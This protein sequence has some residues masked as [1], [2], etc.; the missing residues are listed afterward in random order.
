M[1][2]ALYSNSLKR[3]V[4]ALLLF[5]PTF[6]GIQSAN[7]AANIWSSTGPTGAYVRS[8][9]IAPTATP[10][11][12][13][14]TNG[15]GVYKTLAGSG[16]W[17][18]VNTGLTNRTVTALTVDP[19]S[20]STLYAGSAGNG[21]F[22][23]AN[24]GTAW[25]ATGLISDTVNAIDI[26][27]GT[28]YAGTSAGGVYRSNNGGGLWAQVNNGL[29]NLHVTSIA[30]SPGFA[31]DTTAFAGTIGGGVFKTT[32]DGAN[33]TAVNTN[34]TD[35]QVTAL[36]AS[37]DFVADNT[38][39][40]GTTTGGV[41][42]SS[43]AGTT[44]AAV[45]TGLPAGAAI[46]SLTIDHTNANTLFAA[47]SAGIYISLNGGGQWDPPATTAPGNSFTTSLAMATSASIYAGTG[48]GVYLSSDSGATWSAINSG[49]TA[50]EVKATVISPDNQSKI[51][52]ATSGGGIYIT[53]DQAATWTAGNS[54][55]ANSFAQ[56]IAI[57][58]N[59][60]A[61][62]YAGT[63]NGIYRSTNGGTSWTA[64]TVQPTTADIRALA[65]D[66]SATPA[67]TIYSGSYGGGVF[68]S[69]NSGVNWAATTALPDQNV[70]AL[71]I[72][73]ANTNLYAGTDGGG[74][75]KSSN[76]GTT[77]SLVAASNNGLNSNR[78]TALSLTASTLYAATAAGVHSIAVPGGTQWSAINN[79][80]SSL[81][82]IALAVNPA[83][84]NYLCTG[85]NGSGVFL[86]TNQGA[87]WSAI[88]NSLNSLVVRSLAIDSAT[89]TRI[90]AGTATGGV[91]SLIT[92]PTITIGPATP[93]SFGNANTVGPPSSQEITVGNSGTLDLTVSGIAASLTAADGTTFTPAG[94]GIS[95]GGS[96]PCNSTT[97][98][99]IPGG[100]CT[101]L[102]KFTPGT[103]TVNSATLQ[104]SSNDT[105][106]PTTKDL[107]ISWAG[108]VPP[109]A[110]FTAPTG[111]A[112]IRNPFTIT[113]TALDNSATGLKRV[114]VSLNGGTTW[115]A[116]S[117]K[118]TLAT[119][120][121]VWTTPPVT[122][123]G[124][125]TLLAR[126][127]DN[128]DYVQT[129]L[130][131]VTVT[132]TNTAPDT[133][134]A[135]SPAVLSNQNSATFT[136]SATKYGAPLG[137]ALFEC[138]LDSGAYAACTTPKTYN[139]LTDGAH[140]FSV[141]AAD[142][143]L[144]LPGNVDATPASYTWTVDTTPPITAITAKPALNIN[145]TDA[146]FV[147][148]ANEPGCTY[149][150]TFDGVGPAPCT[151][152]YD[153]TTLA[154]GDHTFTVQATDPAGNQELAPVSYT[155]RIDVTRP[156]SNIDA[157][158][159]QISGS[160]HTFTGT[161]GDPVSVVA[162]GVGRVE[163]SF[164][165]TTWFPATDTAVGPA[166]PWSTWS[167]LW[168]LP[169]NGSYTMQA[170]AV[171]NAGNTQQTAASANVVVA[172]PL[173]TVAITYPTDNAIIGSSSVK[174]ISGSAAAAGGGLPLQK[175]QVT[176]Y[177]SATPPGSPTWV[178]AVGTTSWSYNWTLPSDGSYTILAR[179]L[180]SVGNISASDS[181]NSRSVTVDVTAPTSA[182]D[183]P[184]NPY[185]QG[186]SI[187]A[188]G[189]ADDNLSGV[190][191]VAITITNSSNQT[192]SSGPALFNTISKTWTYSSGVLPD[193]SYTIRSRA[194]DNAGNQQGVQGSATI[195][196]DNVAPIT[197][198]TSRPVNPSNSAAPAFS[199]S[200]DHTSTFICTLDGVAAPCTS[201]KSYS[202]QATGL[203][204]FSVQAI[205]LAGNQEA[206]PP[207]YTWFIDLV[208]PIVTAVTPVNGATRVSISSPNIT[209]TFDKAVDPTT[210]T[211][212]TFSLV[213]GSTTIGGTISL[214][215]T[216]TVA[217]F[218]PS[219]N[220]SYASDYTATV[221]VG[222]RDTAGNSLFAGRIWNFS[223]DPD[224]DINMDGRVD[225]ADALLALRVAVGRTTVSAA[226][227]RHG[228]V[229]PL[230]PQGPDPDGIIEG[231]DVM[232]ILGK[233]IGKHNW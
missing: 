59:A 51:I 148:A 26:K 98:T 29:T 182:V 52:A 76:G 122:G 105:E 5:S 103:P 34:L 38:I 230:G 227:L 14:G 212:S 101:L 58:P 174:V 111:G 109:V 74:V 173:P 24:G 114:E 163:V 27:A 229:A 75:F 22:K 132:L 151:S 81:D 48:G 112:T 220:L 143:A 79:G 40:A 180:D 102:F 223:T 113:G 21:V 123:D 78:I 72:D 92:S 225:I 136:F 198:I 68:K 189:T 30:M 95:V 145:S 90:Y 121:Y 84:P 213:N 8:L 226:A 62:V 209:V 147:F 199:F 133:A 106:I 126:G 12:Y 156:T 115:V 82:T 77:W 169:I 221:T 231:R 61:R 33:W 125:Y 128:K 3:T 160:G 15:G 73:A 97:P 194:T 25:A 203:H 55:L 164:N 71:I 218:T 64:A 23:T 129:A 161:A 118:P 184:A 222:I 191:G 159:A 140:T 146:H 201:P 183:Q 53:P 171:D 196:L 39:Y 232:V 137:G 11:I 87:N 124:S 208:A 162:S 67:T 4:L 219:A 66:S 202:G 193:G 32:D 7:A 185:L 80:I 31:T 177:P 228:D 10:T 6:Q 65:I 139:G 153:R 99:I 215:A 47:T 155:W 130:A 131:S 94:N 91:S 224:G 120:E 119:W 157:P 49:I 141:R 56:A 134:I 9:A 170:R 179:T 211:T 214:N 85:T 70:T 167:Y 13:A 127:T 233:S 216:N 206:A 192:V 104:F 41:F 181:S 175:V 149:I 142:G 186:T 88:N 207:S 158:P 188:T 204:T 35:L 45:N 37:P 200:A 150:C 28:I 107:V 36:V 172:N 2:N 50:V 86:S 195:T 144:P 135:S 210:V 116:A 16:T 190:A 176:V 20:S 154:E 178:D 54:G 110:A 60:T 57:D 165:G 187:N 63:A 43:N 89:P 117:P 42:K 205:D 100:S 18:T 197:T 217:T 138:K 17:S 19:L 46:L 93:H 168:T 44:W 83:N 108:G 152:P 96:S 1:R 166:L 69:L